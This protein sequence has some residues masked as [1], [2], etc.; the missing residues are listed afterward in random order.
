MSIE[1]SLVE[2][3]KLSS[4]INSPTA[5]NALAGVLLFVD[6]QVSIALTASVDQNLIRYDNMYI[7]AKLWY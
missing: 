4:A 5:S 1:P 7:Y 6:P 3:Y 2:A